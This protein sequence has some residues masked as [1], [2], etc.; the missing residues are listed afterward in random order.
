[1]PPPPPPLP[2]GE[3][4][5]AGIADTAPVTTPVAILVTLTAAL[6]TPKAPDDTSEAT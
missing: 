2:Q 5:G 3:T 4:L 1:M 6:A